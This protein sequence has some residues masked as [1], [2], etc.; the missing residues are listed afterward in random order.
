[1]ARWRDIWFF[2]DILCCDGFYDGYS[3]HWSLFSP[4]IEM[5]DLECLGRLYLI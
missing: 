5:V 1:M 3:F 4:W 2:F